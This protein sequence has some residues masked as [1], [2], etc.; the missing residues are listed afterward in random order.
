LIS[1]RIFQSSGLAGRAE[2][3]GGGSSG[4]YPGVGGNYGTVLDQI[5]KGTYPTY[6][7]GINLTAAGA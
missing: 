4:T 5:L 7:V 2:C 6:S 3:L 1:G